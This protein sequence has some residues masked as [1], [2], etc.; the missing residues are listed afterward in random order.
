MRKTFHSVLV[1]SFLFLVPRAGEDG[2][3]PQTGTFGQTAPQSGD[4]RMIDAVPHQDD[5]GGTLQQ[6]VCA[7]GSKAGF[8]LLWSDHREGMTGLYLGRY[9]HDGHIREP[10]RPI[11]QPYAGRRLQPGLTM[12]PEGGGVALWTADYLNVPILYAHAYD[13]EGR[14]QASDQPLTEVPQ[15]MHEASER[16]HGVQLPSAAA[17]EGGGFAVAWTLRGALLW[18]DLKRDGTRRG[19]PQRLNPREQQADPGVQLCGAGKKDP[20]A[21]WHADGRLWSLSLGTPKAQGHDLGAGTLVRSVASADGGAWILVS[22]DK[23]SAVRR[24]R[25]D[26]R[27]EGEAIP[28]C[29]PAEQALDIAVLGSSLAVLVQS[30]GAKAAEAPGRGRGGRTQAVTAGARFQLRM[31]EAGR[32]GSVQPIEFLSDKAKIVGTPLVVSDGAR[33]LLAWTDV[34]EGDPD[35][36]ARLVAPGAEMVLL[37][38]FRA[39][40]DRASADQLSYRL[41]ALGTAGIVTWIDKRDGAPRAYGR[42][43]AAP[44]SFAGDEFPLSAAEPKVAPGPVAPALRPDGSCAFLWAESNG[45]LRLALQDPAGKLQGEARVLETEGAHEGAIEALPADQ[46]WLCTWVGSE[47]AIWCLHVDPQGQPVGKKQR[48]SRESAAPL[49]NV[50]LCFLG[51]RRFVLA[52]EAERALRGLRRQSAGGRARVRGFAAPPGLGP[53][54]RAGR[55]RGL[56]DGLDLRIR[57]RRVARRGRAL[58]RR[59]GAHDGA[60]ALDQPDDQRAGQPGRRAPRGRHLGGRLG[61]RHLRLRQHLCAADR[62]GRTPR[63]A[64]RPDQ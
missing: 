64:D 60:A 19:E 20:L 63:R 58:P 56:R 30:E 41:D 36:Y 5:H 10:E 47:P 44:G 16:A 62:E 55:Q 29:E 24:L 22:G 46:G 35:V 37:P 42:R 38:E 4:V 25:A 13:A 59:P 40:T 15:Q 7:A 43:I 9:D 51:G 54:A 26:G 32:A 49:A 2:A 28:V 3:T 61:G 18:A 57:G 1:G 14:W 33:L 21:I 8:A 6:L 39:N 11:H 31:I 34:R 52:L 17:L 48:L 45:A 23:G 12:D 53:R 50:S 27:P